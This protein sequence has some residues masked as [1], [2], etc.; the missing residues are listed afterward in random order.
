MWLIAWSGFSTISYP[1]YA[2]SHAQHL[3]CE[4]AYPG[5]EIGFSVEFRGGGCQKKHRR[6]CGSEGITHPASSAGHSLDT[7]QCNLYRSV[8]VISCRAMHD[9]ILRAQ[10]GGP[11]KKYFLVLLSPL[12]KRLGTKQSPTIWS[13]CANISVFIDRENLPNCRAGS[14][15]HLGWPR[16]RS[17]PCKYFVI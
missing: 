4:R 11:T 1:E 9:G 15:L 2:R 8:A 5:Y 14:L 17:S 7:V 12:W 13:C 10:V 6:L 3:T 16:W